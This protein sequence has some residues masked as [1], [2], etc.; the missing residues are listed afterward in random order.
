MGVAR[1]G[2]VELY[3]ETFGADDDPV[4]VLVSGIHGDCA[5][6]SPPWC[7]M[8]ADRGFQ[9]VRFDLRDSGLSSRCDGAEYSLA[10]IAEDVLA[11]ASAITSEPVHVYG[12]SL[13]GMI[14]QR[15]A[16]EHPDR[17]LSMT[18]ASS[19]TVEREYGRPSPAMVEARQAL[20]EAPPPTDREGVIQQA[21]ENSRTFGAKPE[22]RDEEF[23]REVVG[24]TY[25]RGSDDPERIARRR[26]ALVNDPSRVDQ[27]R[28]LSVPTLVIHGNRDQNIS[29]DGGQ[30]TA[31]LIPGARLEIIEG[32]AHGPLPAV[33][34]IITDI[35]ADFVA[36]C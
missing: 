8:F 32:M 12:H 33:W 10:D 28:T 25:D 30:R 18:S 11:V 24:M 23:V 13:G 34:P 22:W 20:E 9:V 31:E 7:K 4:L 2:D 29:P 3:Y 27:L 6:F 15:L 16:I 21:I 1:N 14:V 5:L 19:S 36:R 35:W 17:L 26:V